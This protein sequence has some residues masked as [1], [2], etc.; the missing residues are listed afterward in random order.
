MFEMGSDWCKQGGKYVHVGSYLSPVGDAYVKQ[1][2]APA[3]HRVNMCR[4]GV[5]SLNSK[6]MVDPWE[7]L[8]TQYQLTAGV[9]DHFNYELNTRLGGVDDG[10][11]QKKKVQIMLL[12]GADLVETFTLPGVWSPVDLN[13]IL[14]DYGAVS[15]PVLFR[16]DFQ[17]GCLITGNSFRDIF[18]DK[19]C[20]HPYLEEN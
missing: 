5:N 18:R 12:A 15:F 20:L 11:G 6:I 13:H 3:S 2:L 16:A 7:A 4:L 9:L 14:L 17:F 10:T 1:G 8:Q 19:Q